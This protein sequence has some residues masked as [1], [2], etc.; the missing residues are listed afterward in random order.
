VLSSAPLQ[1]NCKWCFVASARDD[2]TLKSAFSWAPHIIMSLVLL[3]R[4]LSHNFLFITFLI[5]TIINHFTG[6]VINTSFQ[7]FLTSYMKILYYQWI[8]FSITHA[9]VFSLVTTER[10]RG[11]SV[12]IVTRLRAG[13]PW[14]RFPV[15]KGF[16]SFRCHVNTGSGATHPPV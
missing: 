10:S 12:N 13:L 15:V 4:L 5:L 3:I 9:G 6:A 16:S 1:V 7:R 8:S 14:F 2:R 11:S